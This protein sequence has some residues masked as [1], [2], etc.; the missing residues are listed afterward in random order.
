MT[1]NF[2]LS[3]REP[4]VGAVVAARVPFIDPRQEVSVNQGDRGVV[5]AVIKGPLDVW[6]FRSSRGKVYLLRSHRTI[7][8]GNLGTWAVQHKPKRGVTAA[9][10]ACLMAEEVGAAVKIALDDAKARRLGEP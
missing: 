8:V 2:S 9:V 3:R 4:V 7:E 5:L 10:E 1:C 6:G